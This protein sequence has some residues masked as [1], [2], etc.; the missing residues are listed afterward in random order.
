[1]PRLERDLPVIIPHLMACGEPSPEFPAP[2]SVNAW[3]DGEPFSEEAVVDWKTF[4]QGLAAFVQALQ[5]VDTS[6]APPPGP[7]NFGRGAPLAG[8]N[9]R[10]HTALNAIAD[11]IDID[12][13]RAAW[14]ED[15][16]APE[17]DGPLRWLHGDLH[18]Q[19]I[20][21][22]EG[23]LRAVIDF[24][25]LG[26]GDP[27]CELSAAWRL[28]PEHARQHFRTELSPDA[29]TWRRARA[30]ALS[31]SMM[32]VQHYRSSNPVLASIAMKTIERVLA[33]RGG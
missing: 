16:I 10:V 5:R 31:I 14:E 29:A 30:W 32:E 19:N 11:S 23:R 12:A 2:W 8:R 33:D 13:A 18:A 22:S 25:C 7:H 1:M 6:G 9:Q 17:W 24:G 28:L 26:I 21:L 4:V 15:S 20:L 27:A 3:I